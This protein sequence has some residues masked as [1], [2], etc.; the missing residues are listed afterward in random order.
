MHRKMSKKQVMTNLAAMEGM[1]IDDSPP[2]DMT[3]VTMNLAEKF[4]LP[5]IFDAKFWDTEIKF[6][7]EEYTRLHCGKLKNLV[8]YDK[9]TVYGEHPTLSLVLLH[10]RHRVLNT[11]GGGTVPVA[12]WVELF[13]NC[14]KPGFY[15]EKDEEELRTLGLKMALTNPKVAFEFVH[16]SIRWL[17]S[18]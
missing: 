1:D 18:S 5:D 11:E 12:K 14:M 2:G 13:N 9:K 16:S 8:G 17:H 10:A 6:M 3:E 4:E 7:T 15:P